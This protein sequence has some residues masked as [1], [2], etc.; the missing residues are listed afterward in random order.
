MPAGLEPMV[1]LTEILC[2]I[3]CNRNFPRI[4]TQFDLITAFDQKVTKKS[5]TK[6]SCLKVFYVLLTPCLFIQSFGGSELKAV[7]L[8]LKLEKEGSLGPAGSAGGN[9][10]GQDRN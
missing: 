8:Y 6:S 3:S 4:I 1:S 9:T 7:K 2:I 10:P 5:R